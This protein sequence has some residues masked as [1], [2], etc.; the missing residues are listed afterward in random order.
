MYAD[1]MT[2]SL[3]AAIT[4]TERRRTIQKKYN[5]EHGI[6]PK[7]IFK[8][9]ADGIDISVKEDKS[10][11]RKKDKRSAKGPDVVTKKYLDS[12]EKEMK[13]AASELDFETAAALRDEIERLGG[14]SLQRRRRITDSEEEI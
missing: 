3:K 12:L 5:E 7:T 11:E 6:T 8:K 13:R 2:A 10:A 14:K 1:T 9:V 4:E